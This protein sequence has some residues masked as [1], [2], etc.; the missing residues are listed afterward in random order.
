MVYTAPHLRHRFGLDEYFDRWV[1]N[2]APLLVL[3]H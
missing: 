3:G 2:K 1:N